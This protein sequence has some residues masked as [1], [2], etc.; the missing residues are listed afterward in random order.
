MTLILDFWSKIVTTR[1]TVSRLF[2]GKENQEQGQD[3]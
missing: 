2:L 3:H 1:I